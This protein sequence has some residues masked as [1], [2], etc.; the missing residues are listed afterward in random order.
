MSAKQL[1]SFQVQAGQQAIVSWMI[2]EVG[3]TDTLLKVFE[4]MRSSL[5]Y[6]GEEEKLES[7]G[8]T[9]LRVFVSPVE[10]AALQRAKFLLLSKS[11]CV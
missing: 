1:L 3:E 7:V 6:C 11:R 2:K 8:L 4:H 5:K 10:T 9:S